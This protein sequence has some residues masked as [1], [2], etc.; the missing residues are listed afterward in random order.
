MQNFSGATNTMLSSLEA[1][2]QQ[3]GYLNP[4]SSFP[5][6]LL[7]TFSADGVQKNVARRILVYLSRAFRKK[8]MK[9][10]IQQYVQTL[11]KK[12]TRGGEP[13]NVI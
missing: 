2:S 10:N 8:A 6:A 11:E 12:I 1:I 7:Q 5:M 3:P 9:Q 13:S 4:T